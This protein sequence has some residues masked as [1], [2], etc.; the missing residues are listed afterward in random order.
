MSVPAQRA[1]R[2]AIDSRRFEPVYY[3]HGDD[4]YRKD[5]AVRRLTQAAVDAATR[6]FNLD[7]YRGGDVDAERLAGALSTLP[8]L[9]ER[10]VVVLRDV[11]A[12]KKTA[13]SELDRYLQRPSTGTVV[14][15]TSVGGDKPDADI[16]RRAVSVGFP[17]LTADQLA[18]WLV[19]HA[20]EELGV[21]LAEDGAKLVTD[22]VG[23]DLA[24]A[25][26]ELDK[27][28]SYAGGRPITAMDVEAIV[29]VRRG[30]TMVDLLDAVAARDAGRALDLAAIVLAQPKTSGVS[31]VSALAFQTLAMAWGRA[32]LD[33]GLS[34]GR[35]D[36]EL[37]GLLKSARGYPGRPWGDAVKCWASNL[38]RWSHGALTRALEQLLAADLALKDTRVSSEDAIVASLVLSLCQARVG[39]AAA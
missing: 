9:A 2:A 3:L 34:R 4:D 23:V 32:A 31:V 15:L 13:R 21:E 19:K 10:R 12:L 17:A 38:H 36:S 8:M 11:D 14:V 25:V 1:L 5:D 24:L 27:L 6:D 7:V 39:S 29:G 33:G 22:S 35:L 26:G 37:M 18:V 16:E 30:E 28:M 20:R